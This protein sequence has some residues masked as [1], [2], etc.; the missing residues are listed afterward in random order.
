MYRRIA[1]SPPSTPM[2]SPSTPMLSPITPT[3][4][5]HVVRNL[6]K[7]IKLFYQMYTNFIGICTMSNNKTGMKIVLESAGVQ[8]SGNE[9]EKRLLSI[10]FLITHFVRS[11]MQHGY[12]YYLHQPSDSPDTQQKNTLLF[13]VFVVRGLFKTLEQ[14]KHTDAVL[15]LSE[16]GPPL[17]ND[18]YVAKLIQIFEGEKANLET[19]KTIRVILRTLFAI[20]KKE[21][22]LFETPFSALPADTVNWGPAFPDPPGIIENAQTISIPGPELRPFSSAALPKKSPPVLELT[23]SGWEER[24]DTDLELALE[25][26]IPR[27][28]RKR[29]DQTPVTPQRKET[30]SAPRPHHS[31]RSDTPKRSKQSPP[32]DPMAMQN[33]TTRRLAKIYGP[34]WSE[35]LYG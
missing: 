10:S 19:D 34:K 17:I 3:S 1:T 28:T 30:Y 8:I 2:L 7:A 23:A 21:S 25:L 29:K 5:S 20:G 26:P 6:D 35:T 15:T 13:T 22:E 16:S 14:Q 24:S 9:L 31:P 27:Q 4:S 32:V 12:G 18:A 11:I 33:E